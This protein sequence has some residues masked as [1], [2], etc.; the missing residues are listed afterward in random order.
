[1]GYRPL[2]VTPPRPVTHLSVDSPALSLEPTPSPLNAVEPKLPPSESPLERACRDNALRARPPSPSPRY[3]SRAFPRSAVAPTRAR[4][5]ARARARARAQ[6][7][8]ADK[9]ATMETAA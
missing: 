8:V 1:M 9:F 6:A 5:R 3:P 4:P 2:T 7:E